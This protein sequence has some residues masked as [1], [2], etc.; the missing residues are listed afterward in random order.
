MNKLD[1][2]LN[3]GMQDMYQIFCDLDGTLTDF[4]KRFEQIP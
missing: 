3:E 2:L 1:E 4:E